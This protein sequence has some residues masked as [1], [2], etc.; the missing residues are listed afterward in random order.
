MYMHIM[1]S[2]L[3]DSSEKLEYYEWNSASILNDALVHPYILGCRLVPGEILRHRTLHHL[4]PHF[5]ITEGAQRAMYGIQQGPRTIAPELEA[6]S[7]SIGLLI[8]RVVE[9]TGCA[10]HGDGAVLQAVDLVQAAR[11]VP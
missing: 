2:K 3:I 11:L 10:N 7:A 4:R 1:D 8:D 5:L 9:A 6:I